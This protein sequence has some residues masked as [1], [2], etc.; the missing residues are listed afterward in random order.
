M[1]SHESAEIEALIADK[2]N[3]QF[4][5]GFPL[6]ETIHP[7]TDLAAIAEVARDILIAIPSGGFRKTL[8]LL[9]A[10]M[11]ANTRV[12]CATKGIDAE[13]DQFLHDA[14]HEVL[15]KDNPLAILSGPTF[16]KEVAA[17]KPTAAVIAS[18]DA[19]FLSDCVARFHSPLFRIDTSDDL[20]GVEIGGVMKNVIAIAAGIVDG[21]QFGANA[22]AALLTRGFQEM[23]RIGTQ[24]GG[25]QETFTGLSGL[26]DLILTCLDDQSRNR[27]FG[28]ALGQGETID[29]AEKRIGQAIEGKRNARLIVELIKQHQLTAP[30][31]EKVWDILQGKVAAKTLAEIF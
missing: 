4:L 5:P 17:G 3:K 14:I 13:K 24:L 23:L 9:K 29:G 8:V 16:A 28:L 2:S 15:G 12:L 26:G 30:I 20:T 19:T 25:R 18:E 10:V 6:P 11:H 27:R 22:R 1:W 7:T 31:M 21:L